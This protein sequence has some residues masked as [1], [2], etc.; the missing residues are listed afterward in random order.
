[1]NRANVVVGLVIV[2]LA[3]PSLAQDTFIQADNELMAVNFD[4]VPATITVSNLPPSCKCVDRPQAVTGEDTFCKFQCNCECDVT[5][6][7][8]DPNC[9]C[10]TECATQEITDFK[11]WAWNGCKNTSANDQ[12]VRMCLSTSTISSINPSYG[13]RTE[14]PL[15]GV[16]CVV[17]DNNPSKGFY[18]TDPGVQTPSLLDSVDVKPAVSFGHSSGVSSSQSRRTKYTVGDKIQSAVAESTT[19]AV[20]AFQGYWPLPLAGL[21]GRC[22]DANPTIFRQPVVA[23]KCIRETKSVT[24]NCATAFNARK[25]TTD[26]LIVKNFQAEITSLSPLSQYLTVTAGTVRKKSGNT[27]TAVDLGENVTQLPVTT[28]NATTNLCENAL[29][30]AHFHVTYDPTTGAAD[31]S[32]ES[33]SVITAITVDAVIMDVSATGH[34][35]IEQEFLVDYRSTETPSSSIDN[36]NNYNTSRSGNPGYIQGRPVLAG[37]K[38]TKAK[39]QDVSPEKNAIA[40]YSGGLRLPIMINADGSCGQIQAMTSFGDQVLF[41]MDTKVGC[42]IT[43]DK[44][45]LETL[46]NAKA[47]PSYFNVSSDVLVGVYGNSNPTNVDPKRSWLPLSVETAPTSSSFS[48]NERVCT[49]LITGV[50]YEFLVAKVG[51]FSKPQ[52]KIVSARAVYKTSTVYMNHASTTKAI[53][54][55]SS[56]TFVPLADKALEEYVPPAPPFLPVLPYDVFYPFTA[57]AAVRSGPAA[58]SLFALV[59]LCMALFAFE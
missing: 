41:G 10:D 55:T 32:K 48:S 28:W 42:T 58:I 1:M 47:V 4:D 39:V 22:T 18:Y 17:K 3:C 9:C 33:G 15:D 31:V 12:V 59:T 45:G 43:V 36:N 30:E 19:A 8:C 37:K 11:Q 5:P 34:A 26:L 44:A 27:Y 25:Y 50:E 6:G 16:M 51:S 52:L 53:V 56:A 35:A 14:G 21:D 7:Q 2:F 20:P 57:S 38:V 40:M 24:N 46:C 23:N 49:N 13:V 29:V 54:L